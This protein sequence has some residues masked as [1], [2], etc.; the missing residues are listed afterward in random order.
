MLLT[1][2]IYAPLSLRWTFVC[3]FRPSLLTRFVSGH[4]RRLVCVVDAAQLI[5]NAAAAR[6]ERGGCRSHGCSGARASTM[7]ISES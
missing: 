4:R 7:R 2:F 3:R 6:R 5:E 1:T